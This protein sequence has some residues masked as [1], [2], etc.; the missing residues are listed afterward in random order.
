MIRPAPQRLTE[1][2]AEEAAAARLLRRIAGQD[3]AAFREFYELHAARLGRFLARLLQDPGLVEEAV[4]DALLAVWQHAG[5]FDP[6]KGRFSTW[7]FGIAHHKGLKLLERSRKRWAEQPLAEASAEPWDD[8]ADE[9]GA[10]EEGRDPSDPERAVLGWEL[11]EVLGRALERL[12]PE[13]RAVL[14]LTFAE[15]LSYQE[16]AG[17]VGCPVNTVKTRVF[18]ARKKLCELIEREGYAPAALIRKEQT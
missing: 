16:I 15:D 3:R 8:D 2:A 17:I 10:D 13:H 6:A 5:D 4:N 7:L 11:G 14:E 18:H 9:A 1:D 12:S